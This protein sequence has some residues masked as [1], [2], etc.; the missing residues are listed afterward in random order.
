MGY[1][2]II[3]HTLRYFHST[4]DY[5]EVNAIANSAANTTGLHG[6][7]HT[8]AHASTSTSM[9]IYGHHFGIS[10]SPLQKNYIKVTGEFSLKSH[11]SVMMR[12]ISMIAI[13]NAISIA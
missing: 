5:G 2:R 6:N 10:K 7:M 3:S 4:E 8:A 12:I 13:T 1:E 11:Q 9:N